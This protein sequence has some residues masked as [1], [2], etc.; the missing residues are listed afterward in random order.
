M[1]KRGSVITQGCL[2]YLVNEDTEEGS[3]LVTRVGF[4]LRV[5]LDD[6]GGSYGREKTSL[7]P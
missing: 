6:K 1:R 3:G 5:D 4:Q 7:V 2:V